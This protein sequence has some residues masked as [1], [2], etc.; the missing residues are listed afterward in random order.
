MLRNIE[1]CI[2]RLV[3]VRMEPI[4]VVFGRFSGPPVLQM[5][6]EPIH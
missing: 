2:F 3:T 1:V 6:V 4:H 5:G